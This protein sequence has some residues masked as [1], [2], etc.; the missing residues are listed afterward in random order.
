MGKLMHS[1][2]LLPTDK[3]VYKSATELIVPFPGYTEKNVAEAF[4]AAKGGVLFIDEADT[5]ASDMPFYR[6]ALDCLFALM[7][8][9]THQVRPALSQQLILPTFHALTNAIALIRTR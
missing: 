2:G 9:P 8:S 6:C 5:L 3:V 4:D 1:V 7:S